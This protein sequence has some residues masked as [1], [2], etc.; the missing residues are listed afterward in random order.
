MDNQNKAEAKYHFFLTRALPIMAVALMVGCGILTLLIWSSRETD[1]I[2]SD[3]QASLMA[4]VVS[5][6]RTA[7]AHDQ[8]SVTVWD[9]AVKQ[10]RAGNAGWMDSNLGSWMHDYFGLDGIYVLDPANQPVYAFARGRAVSPDAF[11]AIAEDVLPLADT[12]RAIQ[13]AG[14]RSQISDR[15]LTPGVSDIAVINRRPAIVSVKPIVSDTGDI[16]QAP[17]EEYLHV[18]VRFLDGNLLD[19]LESDYLFDNLT[20]SWVQDHASDVSS[21]ALLSIDGQVKGYLLWHPYRP[22]LAVM[23]RVIPVLLIVIVIAVCSIAGFLMLHHNR[24]KKL[25]ASEVRIRYL[26]LHDPLTGLPNR[27]YFNEHVDHALSDEPLQPVA[28]LYLDLDRFKQVNDTL[29]HPSGDALIREFGQRLRAVVRQDDVVARIGGDE[30]TIMLRG[31]SDRVELERI[32]ERM[33]EVAQRPFELDGHSVFVGVSIG[34]A[35]APDDGRERVNLLRKADVAL[36]YSKTTGRGRYSFFSEDMDMTLGRRQRIELDLRLALAEG[37]QLHVYY[38][39]I[40]SARDRQIVGYEAL[41]RWNHPES[42]WI[43]PEFFIP[44]AE[45]TGLIEDIGAYVLSE[46]CAAAAFWTGM[47][48]AVNVSAVELRNPAYAEKVEKTLAAAGLEPR[49]LELEVTET[50]ATDETTAAADNL[51]RLR[52]LGVKIAIDDFGTGFSSLGRLQSLNVDR[53]KIDKSFVRGLGQKAGDE[54]IIRAIV[55]LAHARG[56]KTTAEGVETPEQDAGLT[57]IGCDN[58]QGYLYSKAVPLHEL[59][60]MIVAR[61]KT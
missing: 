43:S 34:A 48:V 9:E 4:L 22:G 18:A 49:Q 3:R 39:P 16:V 21:Q 50:A 28:L 45:E 26:A 19:E 38:Q 12:L 44:V 15:V 11:S 37:G 55:D 5:Q 35:L 30:F 1:R 14:D 46:A 60:D 36:Y 32:C 24:S 57:R 51:R 42:G 59:K 40:R 27:T 7:V 61:R 10:T 8:E 13:R 54:A 41:L 33:V 17:G 52:A 31:R 20:F 6:L 53:I 23:Q 56:L 58:L 25:E 47:T 29:G 2:S